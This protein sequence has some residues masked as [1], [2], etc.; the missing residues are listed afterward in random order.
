MDSS[1]KYDHPSPEETANPLSKL[2]FAWILPLFKYG[3]NN[4]LQIKDLYNCAKLDSSGSL[5]DEMER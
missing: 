5:G 1:K 2:C 4:D 3:Y